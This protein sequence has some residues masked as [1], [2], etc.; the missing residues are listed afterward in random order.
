MGFLRHPIRTMSRRLIDFIELQRVRGVWQ[1][2]FGDPERLARYCGMAA[3][4]VLYFSTQLFAVFINSRI[5]T[6]LRE[7]DTR[8]EMITKRKLT[9]GGGGGDT[10][11][12]DDNESGLSG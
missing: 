9:L 3:L 4:P 11:P 8:R 2:I 1:K 6:Q 5:V 7:R 10:K 12:D